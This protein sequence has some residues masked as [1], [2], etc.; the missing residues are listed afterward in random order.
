M[1]AGSL[2]YVLAFVVWAQWL[3]LVAYGYLLTIVGMIDG[4]FPGGIYVL[5]LPY[6]YAIA[7][8]LPLSFG[9]SCLGWFG[10]YRMYRSK[11]ALAVGISSA[12]IAGL[13]AY[14]AIQILVFLDPTQYFF[15]PILILVGIILWGSAI[16]KVRTRF[17]HP[18]L[19]YWAGLALMIAGIFGA[20]ILLPAILFYGLEYW[21]ALLGWLYASATLSTAYSFYHLA[22][23]QVSQQKQAKK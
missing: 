14:S 17:K 6:H 1:Y 11:T 13:F 5:Y 3:L 8:L 9:F 4:D 10:I 23:N 21:F 22:R 18:F 15:R 16:L 2:G 19:E 20:S 7:L 12:I